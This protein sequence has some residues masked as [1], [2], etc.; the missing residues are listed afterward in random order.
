MSDANC[1]KLKRTDDGQ[2]FYGEIQ[3]GRDG[4]LFPGALERAMEIHADDPSL[5]IAAWR[6]EVRQLQL[7]WPTA[8]PDIVNVDRNM[9]VAEA[10]ARLWANL[11]KGDFCDVCQRDARRYTRLF[12][13]E[14]ATFLL[15]LVVKYAT[16]KVKRYFDIREVLPNN[17]MATKASTDGSYLTSWDLVR[18]HPIKTG[19][20]K[21]TPKGEAFVRGSISVP[22]Y[23][24]IYDGRP[25]MYSSETVTITEALGEEIDVLA[26]MRDTAGLQGR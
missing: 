11:D 16:S 20:Y 24:A 17:R 26:M 19:F 1:G 12:H 10:H 21:P 4:E 7:S 23:A 3:I 25:H 22:K 9:T 18:R 13:R 5:D 2:W 14:M 8:A 6:P 15:H